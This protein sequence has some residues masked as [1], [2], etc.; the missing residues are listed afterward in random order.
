MALFADGGLRR[1]ELL[2]LDWDDVDLDRRPIRVRNAKD[3]RQ[4]VVPIHPGLVPA[5]PRLRATRT[6]LG[7]PALFVGVRSNRLSPTILANTFRR[8][9]RAARGDR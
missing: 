1:L 3:G 4:R 9:A 2:G 8:Y 6:P 5:V 7:H